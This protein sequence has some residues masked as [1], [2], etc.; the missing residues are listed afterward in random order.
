MRSTRLSAM[1]LTPERD[2]T[3]GSVDMAT[4]S[5]IVRR[6]A[7]TSERSVLPG[8]PAGPACFL[9]SVLRITGGTRL[10]LAQHLVRRHEERVLLQQPTHDHH[11]VRA[12]DVYDD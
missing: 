10:Q 3:A 2:H 12:H 11:G 1:A 6:S 7:S 4:R 9:L 5:R 8:L